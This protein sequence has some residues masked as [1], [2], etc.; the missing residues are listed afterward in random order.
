MSF[1]VC[2]VL[3]HSN[4][5]FKIHWIR[6]FAF[7]AIE[8]IFGK[9]LFAFERGRGREWM[10]ASERE[11]K[12]KSPALIPFRWLW[13][14]KISRILNFPLEI[15]SPHS[16]FSSSSSVPRFLAPNTSLTCLFR[17]HWFVFNLYC[18]LASRPIWY[19]PFRGGEL[20]LYRWHYYGK[21]WMIK[22]WPTK[23]ESPYC[24]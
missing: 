7:L 3:Q 15:F 19:P 10:E 6:F 4:Q 1:I 13:I 11:K 23:T 20:H 21:L 24:S 22:N 8:S 5:C 14:A 2:Y 12:E 17:K 9:S 16:N 18:R